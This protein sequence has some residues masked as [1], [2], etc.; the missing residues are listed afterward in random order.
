[1]VLHPCRE[2]EGVNRPRFFGF[3][4]LHRVY[5]LVGHRVFMLFYL[6][7]LFFFYVRTFAS[8]W[9]QFFYDI[10]GNVRQATIYAV[11]RFRA[12]S[13]QSRCRLQLVSRAVLLSNLPFLRTTPWFRQG[14]LFSNALRQGASHAVSFRQVSVAGSVILCARHVGIVSLSEG[15]F[16]QLYRFCAVSLG[17][18][19]QYGYPR[20]H[21]SAYRSF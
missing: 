20:Y 13:Y 11:H 2:Q 8:G 21:R 19:F 5:N 10:C 3:Y 17:Q 9:V 14:V 16:F 15:E 12:F 7:W 1:M 18:G 6:V 4:A